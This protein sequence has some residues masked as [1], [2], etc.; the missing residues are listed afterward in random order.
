MLLKVSLCLVEQ[1]LESSDLDPIG[2]FSRWTVDLRPVFGF[3]SQT[4][5]IGCYTQDK[6]SAGIST[7]CE[8]SSGSLTVLRWNSH[9]IPKRLVVVTNLIKCTCG[10]NCLRRWHWVAAEWIRDEISISYL[11]HRYNSGRFCNVVSSWW[12]HPKLPPTTSRG[13]LLSAEET[14]ICWHLKRLTHSAH[15]LYIVRMTLLIRCRML[16]QQ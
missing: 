7:N 14:S 12:K 4:M 5:T 11:S 2:K 13:S 6:P 9:I 8:Q 3:L 10:C 1:P 16:D 15:S